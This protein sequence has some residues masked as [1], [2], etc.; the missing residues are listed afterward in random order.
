[1]LSAEHRHRHGPGTH[2]DDWPRHAVRTPV[3]HIKSAAAPVHAHAGHLRGERHLAQHARAGLE[4][5]GR[6]LAIDAHLYIVCVCV[7]VCVCVCVRASGWVGSG[8]LP[9]P[10]QTQPRTEHAASVVR[11][12]AAPRARAAPWRTQEEP[13]ATPSPRWPSRCAWWSW[14]VRPGPAGPCAA[15]AAGAASTPRCPRPR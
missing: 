3:G 1:M 11:R 9:V 15:P 14:R 6:V 12:C 2:T 4:V 13:A 10:A 8:S 7:Y 5:L